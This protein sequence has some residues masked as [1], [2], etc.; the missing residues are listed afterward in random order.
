MF[1]TPS[2]VPRVLGLIE[3]WAAVVE[4]FP[5]SDLMMLSEPVSI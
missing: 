1:E 2:F 3:Q 4:Y 5:A